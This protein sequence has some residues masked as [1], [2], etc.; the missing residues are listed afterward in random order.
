MAYINNGGG[1]DYGTKTAARQ[2]Q[3]VIN[4]T[5]E[6]GIWNW[7]VRD[8]GWYGHNVPTVPRRIPSPYMSYRLEKDG[9]YA[10]TYTRLSV[11]P[12]MIANL[13]EA[14]IASQIA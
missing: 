4:D 6:G 2:V 10:D 13:Y 12:D 14:I 7:E 5:H 3:Q 8:W 1:W 9:L 11:S